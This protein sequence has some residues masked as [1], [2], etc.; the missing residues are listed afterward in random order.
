MDQTILLWVLSFA[1][2]AAVSA[3][4]AKPPKLNFTGTWK[5]NFAKSKLQIRAPESTVFIIEHNEPRFRLSR[6]HVFQGQS[7][8]WSIELTTDGKEVVRKE[9]ERTL[10]C[11]MRWQGD[12]LV[13]SVRIV[14]PDGEARD[15]V[16]YVLS[17]DGE[18]FTAFEHYRSRTARVDNV[19]IL[20]KQE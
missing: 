9:K 11:R 14:L 10:Y 4:H 1:L 17:P 3:Q 6:T 19:W 13:F 5:A 20:E 7:D 12:A 8:T 16:K 2:P 15:R 18:T